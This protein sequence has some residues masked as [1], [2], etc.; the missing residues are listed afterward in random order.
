MRLQFKILNWTPHPSFR[1]GATI[2]NPFKNPMKVIWCNIDIKII[3]RCIR[4]HFP[5]F[6]FILL[7]SV[8]F[9]GAIITELN[10][11]RVFFLCRFSLNCNV[12]GASLF[13]T[14]LH[15]AFFNTAAITPSD[16]DGFDEVLEEV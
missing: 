13:F 4:T 12:I 5:L 2:F 9:E 16:D 6:I 15:A 7:C 3:A 1:N 11:K 14:T 10:I 8:S